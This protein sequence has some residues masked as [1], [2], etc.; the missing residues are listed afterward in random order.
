[1]GRTD[2]NVVMSQVVDEG[3][4]IHCL[5]MLLG[6]SG[7]LIYVIICFIVFDNL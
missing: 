3:A 2:G 7:Y 4:K 6:Y 5:S 1:M